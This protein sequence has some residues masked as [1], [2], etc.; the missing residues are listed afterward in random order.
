MLWLEVEFQNSITRGRCLG[1]DASI[2]ILILL[3]KPFPGT[4]S[5]TQG[6]NLTVKLHLRSPDPINWTVPLDT[7][8]TFSVTQSVRDNGNSHYLLEA[9]LM[10]KIRQWPATDIGELSHIWIVAKQNSL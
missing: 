1:K 6:I 2:P 4:I 10:Q 7:G 8:K 9:A 5:R 3:Q